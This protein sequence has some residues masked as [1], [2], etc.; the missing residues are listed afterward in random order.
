MHTREEPPQDPTKNYDTRDLEVKDIIKFVIGFFIFTAAM[1]PISCVALKGVGGNVG[2][3]Y[4]GHE[5]LPEADANAY[6][7]RHLPGKPNPLLQDNVTA[8][9]DIH[10][11]RKHEQDILDGKVPNP[12]YPNSIAIDQAIDVEAA[13]H[14]K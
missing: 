6:D 9:A 3:P 13:K 7:S 11:L 4:V 8:K 5:P 10:N 14:S 2:A 1:G 12:A